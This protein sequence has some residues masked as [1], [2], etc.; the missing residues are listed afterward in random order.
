[1]DEELQRLPEVVTKTLDEFTGIARAILGDTL[2]SLVLFGSAAEDR[3][4]ATSDVN[5]LFVLSEWNLGKMDSLRDPLRNAHAAITLAPMFVLSSELSLVSDA[6]AVKFADMSRRHRVLFG[7]DPFTTLKV[8]RDAEIHRLRQ[9]LLNLQLRL[10]ERYLF[11]SQ[12]EEQALK[13][14]AGMSGPIRA[15]AATYL[16]LSG[17]PVPSPKLA[18]ETLVKDER[19]PELALLLANISAA[20]ERKPLAG[21]TAAWTLVGML[22]LLQVLRAQAEALS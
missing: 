11:T 20:R 12:R 9:V 16:G 14:V 3:L 5:L 4:R 18:L 15:C 6:F 8:S 22:R 21:K 10:R 19:D 2:V 13:V 17:V 7:P 1:M